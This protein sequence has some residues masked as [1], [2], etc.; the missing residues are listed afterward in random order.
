M[1]AVGPRGGDLVRIPSHS[2]IAR[3][4]R[5]SSPE[6]HPSAINQQLKSQLGPPWAP[7][8]GIKFES[9]ISLQYAA[10]VSIPRMTSQPGYGDFYVYNRGY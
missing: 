3:G 2:L 10:P 5:S 1:P 6:G 7:I 4:L 8:G 9:Q